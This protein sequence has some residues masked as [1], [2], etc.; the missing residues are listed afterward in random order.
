MI[1]I[2]NVD[3]INSFYCVR[4]IDVILKKMKSIN[5]KNVD[6]YINYYE[7]NYSVVG[8]KTHDGF[9][10]IIDLYNSNVNAKDFFYWLQNVLSN[11]EDYYCVPNQKGEMI[12]KA[13]G[14]RS[15]DIFLHFSFSKLNQKRVKLRFIKFLFF[16]MFFKL[17]TKKSNLKIKKKIY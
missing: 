3:S 16:N 15:N 17:S 6:Y 8:V 9:N 7:D 1:Y 14:L 13:F 12:W 5:E 4:R 10:C 2:S 11:Y